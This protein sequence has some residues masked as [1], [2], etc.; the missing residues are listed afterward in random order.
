MRRRVVWS[1]TQKLS[2]TWKTALRVILSNERVSFRGRVV[3]LMLL[4]MVVRWLDAR[5]A[6]LMRLIGRLV[7]REKGRE[8]QRADLVMDGLAQTSRG[9]GW[10]MESR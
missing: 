6:L 3:T 10:L 9:R 8:V 7:S 4:L 5:A 1:K 2:S